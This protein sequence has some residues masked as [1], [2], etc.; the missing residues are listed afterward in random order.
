M[1]AS[2]SRRRRPGSRSGSRARTVT[3][4][5]SADFVFGTLATDDL[6]LAQ[7]RAAGSGLHH[8]HDLDPADP[9]PEVPVT[10]G[11]TLGPSI[12][13]D[14]VT[15]Y[16]TTD[17]QD[18][19]GDRGVATVGVAIPLHRVGVDW[20]TL[21]WGYRERW[22]GTIPGQ[23]DGTLV[24]YRIQAWSPIHDAS[25]WA[26]DI[27]GVVAGVR[28]PG[29]SDLDAATFAVAGAPTLWPMRRTA[30]D[31]YHVDRERVP[32]W[33]RDA[34]IYQVFIDRFATTGGVPFAEPADARRVLRRHAC[35]ACSSGSPISS[36]SG[37]PACGSPRSSRARRTM[38]TTR[39]TTARSSRGSATEADLRELVDAAHARRPARPARLRGE[40]PLLGPP[41][42]PGRAARPRRSRSPLVHVHRL[43]DR[44]TC[45]SS[46]CATI[47]SSTPTIPA[48]SASSSRPP[49]TGSISASTASGATTP[50]ARRTRSGAS[51]GPRP[52]R[53]PPDSVTIGEIVETPALQRTF[54]G[55]LDGCLDFG[56]HQAPARARSGSGRFRPARSRPSSGAI[57]RSS[58]TDAVLPCFLDNHDMNR[59]LWVVRGDTRKLRLAALYQATLPHPPIVYYG[60]EVGLSQVRDVR[61]ADGSGHPEESRL[62]MRWGDGQDRELLAAYRA[63]IAPPAGDMAAR[64]GANGR[65]SRSTTRPGSSSSTCADGDRRAVVA[66]HP[67]E[68]RDAVLPGASSGTGRAGARDDR[69][70]PPGGRRPALGAMGRRGPPRG[71]LMGGRSANRAYAFLAAARRGAGRG[72]MEGRWIDV[73]RSPDDRGPAGRDRGRD[74]GRGDLAGPDQH[75]RL[76][77]FRPYRGDPWPHGVQEEDGVHWQWTRGQ[78]RADDDRPDP[79]DVARLGQISIRRPSGR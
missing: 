57:S 47:R 72:D 13:A 10:V 29:V 22:E 67:G 63:L 64:G 62:P 74:H 68:R 30:A 28:P 44:A 78:R 37:S 23:P 27:A 75:A 16:V 70:E 31:A 6:R 53:R 79:V 56:L 58:P 15:A 59:F 39:P 33:L 20:D 43:A 17:G 2:R 38:A 1:A 66:V 36:T 76:S 65:R 48:R 26:S 51:S 61:S 3:D 18:P 19:A 52:G 25:T 71:R 24:R 4:D 12:V 45:R 60:T 42:V 7:L 35:A 11:V 9:D 34:V 50:R 55:R 54:A 41:G 49:G 69:R 14:R 73:D 32:A 40:P 77:L 8:G 21:L 46:A 5:V